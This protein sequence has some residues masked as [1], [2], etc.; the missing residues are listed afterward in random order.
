MP[1]ILSSRTLEDSDGRQFGIVTFTDISEQ[2]LA[3]KRSCEANEQLSEAN[4]QLEACQQDIE[5]ALALAAR[6]L[7]KPCASIAGVGG[8]RVEAY[9]HPR[10]RLAVTSA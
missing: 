8:L 6:L 5:E 4:K 10:A 7:A 3:Q 2:E 1:V 9:Y